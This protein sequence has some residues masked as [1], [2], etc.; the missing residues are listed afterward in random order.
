MADSRH[1]GTTYSI[2]RIIMFYLPTRDECQSL[3]QSSE[4]FFCTTT[5][6]EG[7]TVEM[8]N[9]R[10]AGYTDFFPE[11]GSNWTELRG[12]T[13]VQQADG[14]WERNILL[15][16]FF[17][18]N[19][20]TGWMY[21]D[22]KDKTI[23]RIQN[24]EDGS[25]ISFVKFANGNVRAKS[26]MS[27]TSPQAMMAQEVYDSDSNLRSAIAYGFNAGA[28]MIFELVSPENQI[29]LEYQKTELR[30]LQVR[31]YDGRY[32]PSPGLIA[33]KEGLA[34]AETFI[35]K[36]L[37]DLLALKKTSQDDI[38]GWVVTF[39]DGQMAKIKTD[40][41]L[42]L[43][44]LIGPDAFRENLLVQTIL[45]GNI[46]DVISALVPGVKKDKLVALA[47]KVEHQFNTLV[48]EFFTLSHMYVNDYTS[49]RKE[50]AIA[51]K[52]HRMFSGFMKAIHTTSE[53]NAER[54][55]RDYILKQCKSLGSAKQYLEGL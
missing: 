34:C 16:K 38:E 11:D 9:Y 35:N 37:D 1:T 45:D 2:L 36:T 46:D 21:E 49:D 30:L 33:E 29:V 52:A 24:K 43:H 8:Y 19:Q 48:Q 39:E 14:N 6:V 53:S 10:L 25:V 12:V 41:Y 15:N 31:E 44:G 51:Y 55:A 20:T 13:F 7:Q 22:V 17:N 32:H 5:I 47:A 26:K 23:T 50:F 28:T 4:A 3:I 18:V 40:K 54:A 27:F 42:Q